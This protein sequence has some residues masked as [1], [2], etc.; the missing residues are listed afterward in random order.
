MIGLGIFDGR[1]GPD[2]LWD[3]QG[4]MSAPDAKWLWTSLAVI[5]PLQL[6]SVAN[7]FG[8]IFTEMGRQPWVVFGLMTTSAR[9]RLPGTQ[10]PSEAWTASLIV[11]HVALRVLAVVEVGLLLEVHQAGAEPPKSR[12]TR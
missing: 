3:P 12:P 11:L 1:W 5:L 9:W 8:W 10:R 7:S 2:A 6:W 4:Q